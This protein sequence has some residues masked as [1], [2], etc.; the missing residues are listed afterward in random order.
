M[1]NQKKV[2]I[3]SE[4]DAWFLRN[5]QTDSQDKLIA[6]LK[7]LEISPSKVLEIGCSSG[8]RLSQ[9]YQTFGSSCFGIDPSSKAIEEGKIANPAIHFQTGTADALPFE[10]N[11]F[12]LLIFGFCLYV[13][14]R[15][16]LFKIAYEADRCLKDNGYLVIIDFEPPFA[17][18]NSYSHRPGLFSYKMDYGKM[19]QW[20]PSYFEIFNLITSHYENEKRRDPNE[21]IS[22]K[23][24]EKNEEAAYILDPFRG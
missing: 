4:G 2:F 1:S 16:E 21:R 11:E 19:F 7:Q 20:N 15:N 13:C 6:I 17:F 18:R 8:N 3:E 22:F 10:N 24:I 12:D 23:I 9:I 5:S 14:D